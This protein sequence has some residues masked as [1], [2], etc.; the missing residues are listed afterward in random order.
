MP[1]IAKATYRKLDGF[2]FYEVV[3]HFVWEDD[4][5]QGKTV[6]AKQKKVPSKEM[7]VP[8]KVVRM[9]GE[10]TSILD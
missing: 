10:Q 7:Q 8:E 3:E 5:F 6:H 2:P 4:E 1:R 9:P